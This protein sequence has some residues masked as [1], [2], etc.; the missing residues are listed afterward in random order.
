[1]VRQV[2][3]LLI[4]FVAQLD[5]FKIIPLVTSSSL[6]FSQATLNTTGRTKNTTFIFFMLP[7]LF[8]DGKQARGAA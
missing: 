6:S 4:E 5:K 7:V 3:N 1:M 2:L 8:Y